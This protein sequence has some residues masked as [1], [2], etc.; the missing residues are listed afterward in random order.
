MNEREI[1]K[2]I[3]RHLDEG[4][5]SLNQETLNKLKSA[6]QEALSHYHAHQPAFR[7]AGLGH[8]THSHGHGMHGFRFWL[9]AIALIM[10]LAGVLYWQETQQNSDVDDVDAA[11]LAGDLPIHAYLDKDFHAWLESSSQ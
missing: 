4:A 6:R 3:T 2:K 11:L 7:L 10:A 9:P 1:A 5:N 8:S